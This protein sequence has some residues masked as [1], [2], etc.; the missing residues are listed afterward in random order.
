MI[1]SV[2]KGQRGIRSLLKAIAVHQNV[3][4]RSLGS[5]TSQTWVGS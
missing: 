2:W 1:N 5:D 4:V 3:M